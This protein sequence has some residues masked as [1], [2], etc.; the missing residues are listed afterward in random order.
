MEQTMACTI[1]LFK[2]QNIKGLKRVTQTL[3]HLPG[4]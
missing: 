1:G 2:D 3:G 4:G